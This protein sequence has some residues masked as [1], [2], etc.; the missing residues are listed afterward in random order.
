MHRLGGEDFFFQVLDHFFGATERRDDLK[1]VSYFFI[2]TIQHAPH[3]P[4]QRRR[5]ARY[6]TFGVNP[7]RSVMAEAMRGASRS[8]R[9]PTTN[10]GGTDFEMVLRPSSP[11]SPSLQTLV[12]GGR[13]SRVPHDHL[14]TRP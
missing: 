7:L 14:A 8:R 4:D 1:T 9:P 13:L 2:T 10:L 12:V 11:L 6:Q 5:A 3:Q